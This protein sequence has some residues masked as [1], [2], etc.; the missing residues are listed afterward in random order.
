GRTFQEALDFMEDSAPGVA[1]IDAEMADEGLTKIINT[2]SAFH[3]ETAVIIVTGEGRRDESMKR[4]SFAAFDYICWTCSESELSFRVA[5]AFEMQGRTLP[6]RG[7]PDAGL[8]RDLE[9]RIRELSSLYNICQE[10]GKEVPLARTLRAITRILVEG[11]S[12]PSIVVAEIWL[13]GQRYSEFPEFPKSG[14]EF[15]APILVGRE[16]RGQ[17]LVYACRNT[18]F[19]SGEVALVTNTAKK[20]GYMVRRSELRRALYDSENKHRRLVESVSEGIF[21]AEIQGEGGIHADPQD[22]ET[23]LNRFLNEMRVT[24]CNLHFASFYGFHSV[25]DCIGMPLREFFATPSAARSY[26]Q[27]ILRESRVVLTVERVMSGDRRF[28]VGMICHLVK[29]GNKIIGI[30]G[31]N[32]DLTDV[33]SLQPQDPARTGGPEKEADPNGQLSTEALD[34]CDCG[35]VLADLSG[36]I[37][38][39]NPAQGKFVGCGLEDLI[40]S[41]V[42]RFEIHG[43][44][45]LEREMDHATLREGSWSGNLLRR[46]TDGELVP[47]YLKTGLVKDDAGRMVAQVRIM[48]DLSEQVR[49]QEELERQSENLQRVVEERTRE[50]V[51]SEENYRFLYRNA[52]IGTLITTITGTILE[53]NPAACALLKYSREEILK[54]N[55]AFLFQSL[56]RYNDLIAKLSPGGNILEEE[57]EYRSRDGSELIMQQS[58]V[59]M[60]PQD[61]DILVIHFL[62]DVTQARKLAKDAENTQ[63]QIARAD[64]LASLGQLAAGVAHELNNPLTA[65]L[66]YAHLLKRRTQQG[67]EIHHQLELIVEA[68]TR[69]RQIVRDLLDFAREKKPTKALEDVDGII[70]HV[71]SLMRNQIMIRKVLVKERLSEDL[72]TIRVDRPQIEQVLVNILLNGMEAM[73]EGGTLTVS[74]GFDSN[75]RLIAVSVE[76]TGTGISS[77][78]M[79]KIFNP[80]FTTKVTGS[81]TGLGLSVSHR[82]I[83]DHGGHIRVASR[84]GRGSKFTIE[85]PANGHPEEP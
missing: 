32:I 55:H 23:V 25:R 4:T 81:G 7:S 26:F 47:V 71:L 68:G 29:R 78:D 12:T 74:S 60:D 9:D 85:I 20:V 10:V 67:E 37:L 73:P 44:E 6:E 18:R 5:R 76:D 11:M 48:H 65:V 17:L 77:E 8:K 15:F 13:D 43:Q 75:R 83:N 80:F 2:A 46:R 63:L 49:L 61:S 70:R 21:W 36:T 45:Q 34:L 84:F 59:L 50:L 54:K 52:P 82:I 56:D 27:T 39:A 64:K 35:V 38:Y 1:V 31:V 53:A 79:E 66:T 58:S 30:Q 33:K 41:N 22:Q 69:C 72:P 16:D 3:P 42:S 40:G 62:R 51:R 28:R 19:T 24:D 14:P 57:I